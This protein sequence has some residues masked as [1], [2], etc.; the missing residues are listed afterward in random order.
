MS[1]IIYRPPDAAKSVL[2]LGCKQYDNLIIGTNTLHE[3]RRSDDIG[4]VNRRYSS[5]IAFNHS[6]SLANV[7]EG[8][9]VVPKS[10]DLI[11]LLRVTA[12]THP[13][14]N[15]PNLSPTAS[16]NAVSL[17]NSPKTCVSFCLR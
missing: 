4:L 16:T 9:D 8:D 7:D 13:A 11:L 17:S 5:L 10:V 3:Y 15:R 1:A 14:F 6:D 12:K 2:I